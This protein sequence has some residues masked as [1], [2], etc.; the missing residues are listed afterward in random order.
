MREL[1][2]VPLV[3]PA[4]VQLIVHSFAQCLRCA[5]HYTTPNHWA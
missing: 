1:R 3:G 5:E 2:S 4:K